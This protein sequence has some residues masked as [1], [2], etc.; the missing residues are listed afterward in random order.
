MHKFM[1]SD[2]DKLNEWIQVGIWYDVSEATVNAFVPIRFACCDC[3]GACTLLCWTFLSFGSVCAAVV[4]VWLHESAHRMMQLSHTRDSHGGC[5]CGSA[6]TTVAVGKA[7]QHSCKN[8]NQTLT[9]PDHCQQTVF[10]SR[11]R[12]LFSFFNCP[13]AGNFGIK[14]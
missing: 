10:Q 9:A 1:W 6:V 14:H 12:L 8:V 4:L 7:Y 5:G 3:S 11:H 2:R 13:K